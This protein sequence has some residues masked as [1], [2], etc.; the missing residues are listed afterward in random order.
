MKSQKVYKVKKTN[1][2]NM[3]PSDLKWS[4]D[5]FFFY[6]PFTLIKNRGSLWKTQ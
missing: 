2:I 4:L 1:Y 3:T 5:E 6:N